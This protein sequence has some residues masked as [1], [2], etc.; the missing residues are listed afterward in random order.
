M[1]GKAINSSGTEGTG[2]WGKPAKW[3]SYWGTVD[4]HPVGIA[5]LDHPTNLRH[6]TTWHAREY[7]LITANPFGLYHFTGA[8]KGTGEVKLAKG[9]TLNLRYRIVFYTGAHDKQRVEDHFAKFA[10]D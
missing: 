9:E 8:K 4:Q 3:V 5:I 6:P 7:G 2:I 10:A 1:T